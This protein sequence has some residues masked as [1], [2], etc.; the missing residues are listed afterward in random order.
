LL[1]V[2]TFQAILGQR[3]V[4]ARSRSQAVNLCRS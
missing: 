4:S 1:P 3:L 2:L